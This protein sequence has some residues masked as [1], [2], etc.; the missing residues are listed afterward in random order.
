MSAAT[1]SR[2]ADIFREEQNFAWWIYAFL[3]VW[4]GTSYLLPTLTRGALQLPPRPSGWNLEVPLISLIGLGLPSLL[5]VGVLRM[6]TEVAVD[7]VRV[8]FGWLPTYRQEVALSQVRCV[9]VVRYRPI[10]DFG[11][12]G[13]RRGPNGERVLSARGDRGVRLTMVDGTKLLIGSQRPEELAEALDKIIR[14][15]A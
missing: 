5:V 8:W 7:R 2:P 13:V 12:W 3:A 4:A 10:I 9:E 14:P 1:L 11:F 6:T 15:V